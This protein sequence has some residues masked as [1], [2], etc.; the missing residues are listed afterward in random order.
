MSKTKSLLKN[1]IEDLKNLTDLLE[2]KKYHAVIGWSFGGSLPLKISIDFP[3]FLNKIDLIKVRKSLNE[4]Q[5]EINEKTLKILKAL[6][7]TENFS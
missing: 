3:G 2:I 5:N 6:Q 4:I 1:E 7:K